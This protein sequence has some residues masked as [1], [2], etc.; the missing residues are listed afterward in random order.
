MYTVIGYYEETG[1]TFAEHVEA[2]SQA[3]AFE[4]LGKQM[5]EEGSDDAVFVCV[6]EGEFLGFPGECT[7]S[8]VSAFLAVL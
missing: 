3:E 1:E 5:V 7:V 2:V 6:L 8:A 4:V